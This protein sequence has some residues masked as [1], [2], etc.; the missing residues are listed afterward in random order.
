MTAV[1][2][3]WYASNER[4]QL[5]AGKIAVRQDVREKGRSGSPVG[6]SDPQVSWR[7]DDGPQKRFRC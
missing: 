4:A 1:V 7:S 3:D 6:E 2:D 5:S